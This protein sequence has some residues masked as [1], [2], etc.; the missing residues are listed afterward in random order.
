MHIG[1]PFSRQLKFSLFGHYI[2]NSDSY[3]NTPVLNSTDTL[4]NL[5]LAG[6]RSGWLL[7]T[8]NLNRKQYPSAGKNMYVK[9]DWF[10]VTQKYTPGNTD[11]FHPANSKHVGYVRLKFS[12]EQYWKTRVYSTGYFVEGVFSNQPTFTNYYG[13]L[14]NAPGFYPM[15]DSRTLLLSKFRSFNYIGGG[16]RNIFSLRSNLDLRLEGYVFKP[17]EAILQDV[18]LE[19]RLSRDL[20]RVSFSG[21]AALVLHSTVGPISLSFNYYDDKDNQFGLLLHVGYLLFQKTSIE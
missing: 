8:N 14:I 18:N 20:T 6:W 4:D 10:T 1:F 5:K 21:M 9:F 16:I 17:I 3:A 7:E 13:T 19:T 2:N 12:A 11:V 15:Q